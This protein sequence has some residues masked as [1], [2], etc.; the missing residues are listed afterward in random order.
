MKILFGTAV[1]VALCLSPGVYAQDKHDPLCK[2]TKLGTLPITVSTDNEVLTSGELNGTPI[3]FAVDTAFQFSLIDDAPGPGK[4]SVVSNYLS[5]HRVRI[6][7]TPIRIEKIDT[8]KAGDLIAKDIYMHHSINR[9][10]HDDV[11]GILGKNFLERY[12]VEIDLKNNVI[13]FYQNEACGDNSAYWT[14]QFSEADLDTG[15]KKIDVYVEV[16]GTRA[17]AI[18]DTAASESSISWGLAQR[19]GISLTSPGTT[20]VPEGLREE[21]QY[22]PRRYKFSEIKIGDEVVKGTTIVI[23]D[24]MSFPSYDRAYYR[25]SGEDMV[26]GVDFIR[27]HHI[28]ISNGDNKM[29][30]TWNGKSIFSQ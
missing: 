7:N 19:L 2:P 18:L 11:R 9:I 24:F 1:V 6:L 16:N 13:N 10:L 3:Q 28:Y 15:D 21:T 29:Y 17:R 27:N 5:G 23:R 25:Y 8:L 26:L 12:N 22:P 20:D 30:F 4:E 14:N